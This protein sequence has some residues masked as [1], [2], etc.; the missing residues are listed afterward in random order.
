MSNGGNGVE[1]DR[2]M[3]EMEDKQ[4]RIPGS[5]NMHIHAPLRIHLGLVIDISES[6][7]RPSDT[8]RSM[9]IQGRLIC[10]VP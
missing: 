7:T 1:W 3:L 5:L 9:L 2:T 8:R 4:K 10:I 6:G